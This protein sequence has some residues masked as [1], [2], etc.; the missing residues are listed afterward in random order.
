M[1][2]TPERDRFGW[3]AAAL[4]DARRRGQR[5]GLARF[6]RVESYDEK[7]RVARLIDD[8]GFEYDLQLK[9]TESAVVYRCVEF[10]IDEAAE[11]PKGQ[12]PQVI[13]WRPGRRNQAEDALRAAQKAGLAGSPQALL[14]MVSRRVSLPRLCMSAGIVIGAVG[15]WFVMHM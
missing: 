9:Q 4:A 12:L 15:C 10:Q 2:N 1:S 7:S 11:V 8:G 13:R 3:T 14:E 6:G 5:P